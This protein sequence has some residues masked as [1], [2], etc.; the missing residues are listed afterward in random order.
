MFEKRYERN[1][2]TY[3]A[4]G[5]QLLSTSHAAI[6]GAGGLGGVVFE[7]LVR[8]GVGKITIADADVFDDS[9]LN[10][11]LLSSERLIGTPKV[12]SAVSRASEINSNVKVFSH[13]EFITLQNGP[14]LFRDA[15]VIAD[16]TDSIP[17]RYELEEI[18]RTLKVPMV[19]AAIAGHTGQIAVIPPNEKVIEKIYGEKTFAP[20]KGAEVSVG[21]PPEAVFTVASLQANKIITILNKRSA[22]TCGTL[23][24]IDLDKNIISKFTFAK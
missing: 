2:G 23:L 16:C 10:R 12:N 6:V 22:P 7:I 11:Q 20:Q 13:K 19:H 1:I 18:A 3:S 9:N 21:A 17:T 8:A 4:R 14:S 15:H 24:R 5:Q